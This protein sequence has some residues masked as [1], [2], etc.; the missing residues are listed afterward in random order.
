MIHSTFPISEPT[1]ALRRSAICRP[2]GHSTYPE[3]RQA[4]MPNGI[5]MI[6]TKQMSPARK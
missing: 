2:N 4:A 5:V 1:P 3:I 6:S